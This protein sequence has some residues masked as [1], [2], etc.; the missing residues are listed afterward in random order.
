MPWP[1]AGAQELVLQGVQVSSGGVRGVWQ[2]HGLLTKHERLL[3]LEKASAERKLTLSE[4]Q[5]RLLER[6]SPEFRER[7]IEAPHTGA[8]VAVDTFFVGVLK[9]VG[10]VYLQTAIDCHSRHA[11]AK[12]YPNK[13]PITAVQLMNNDV[14]PTFKADA[15]RIDAVLSDNGREFCGRDDQRPYELFLQLEEIEHKRTRVKRPQSNGIV[16]RRHQ[17]LLDEHFR[18]EGR[19][20][21]FETIDEMQGA[22][23]TYLIGYNTKRPHQGRGMNG[24]T[25]MKAFIDGLPKEKPTKT[26]TSPKAALKRLPTKA[27]LSADHRLCTSRLISGSR[28]SAA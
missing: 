2:R 20:T 3:R 15:A 16:E 26:I 23:D 12:L 1:D 13:L 8:L 22:L 6:F 9:G 11:W 21:W 27:A 28:R 14:L 5:V 18:V 19:R 25:P 4:D 24:R 7:H 17:T 10:K